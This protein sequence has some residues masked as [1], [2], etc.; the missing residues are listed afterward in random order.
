MDD[1]IDLDDFCS[2]EVYVV[3]LK[4]EVINLTNQLERLRDENAMLRKC[5]EEKSD[6]E[7]RATCTSPG[8]GLPN[9]SR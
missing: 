3:F 4:L 1:D 7:I 2:S 9:N 5:V 8:R 6:E